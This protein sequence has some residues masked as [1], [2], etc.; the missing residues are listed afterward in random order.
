MKR[1]EKFYRSSF[2]K[3]FKSSVAC[4]KFKITP[5]PT[6]VRCEDSEDIPRVIDQWCRY[7]TQRIDDSQ[8]FKHCVVT[9]EII[10]RST[11]TRINNSLH[12]FFFL[13]SKIIIE[14]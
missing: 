9:H 4:N 10:Q 13:C 8:S 12:F 7:F 2:Q 3:M 1:S 11:K 5:L 14:L 6:V